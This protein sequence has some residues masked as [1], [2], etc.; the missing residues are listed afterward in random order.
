MLIS[1]LD[2]TVYY[3]VSTTTRIT[4]PLYRMSYTIQ[5]KISAKSD[6]VEMKVNIYFDYRKL[7]SFDYG[8]SLD[9]HRDKLSQS[10]LEQMKPFP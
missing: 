8:C 1:R 5:P 2:S 4:D 10:I 9:F 6:E 3:S 7:S